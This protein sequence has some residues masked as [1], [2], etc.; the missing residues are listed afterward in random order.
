MIIELFDQEEG[1][2]RWRLRSRTRIQGRRVEGLTEDQLKDL[3]T[4][5]ADA[6]PMTVAAITQ[7]ALTRYFIIAPSGA[8]HRTSLE[9][10]ERCA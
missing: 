6:Q 4:V 8:V 1:Q 10:L 7:N 5:L 2:A 9:D 3:I